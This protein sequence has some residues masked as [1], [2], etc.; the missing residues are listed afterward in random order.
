PPRNSV[1]HRSVCVE[2]SARL[3]RKHLGVP[4]IAAMSLTARARL[5]QPTASGGC[6]SRR[7]CVPSTDQ[8]HVR[9]S[10][11]PARGLNSAA[12]S[13]IP[14]WTPAAASRPGF[15]PEAIFCRTCSSFIAVGLVPRKSCPIP[16]QLL[17]RS[18]SRLSLYFLHFLCF[19]NYLIRA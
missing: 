5:F 8:A 11:C 6:L 2:G 13:P 1:N 12:S 19:L 3:R 14:R 15:V 7:K 10:C 4:P 16:D 18:L 17:D 9:I